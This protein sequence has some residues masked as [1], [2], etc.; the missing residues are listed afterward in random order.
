MRA[1]IIAA[2]LTLAAVRS[3][4]AATAIEYGLTAFGP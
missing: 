4:A 3:A 2:I 1:P